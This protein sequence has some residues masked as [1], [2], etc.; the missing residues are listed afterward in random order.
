[1][2]DI[3]QH[4]VQCQSRFGFSSCNCQFLNK[5]Q[6]I[7][8][9]PGIEEMAAK[10]SSLESKLAIAIEAIEFVING[11]ESTRRSPEDLPKISYPALKK[12]LSKINDERK[13]K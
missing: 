7:T 5:C 13:D 6:P 3:N 9:A 12:A 2:I 1:M 11:W 4:H 8:Y 10:I